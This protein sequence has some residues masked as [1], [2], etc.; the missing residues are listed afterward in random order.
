MIF[1][2]YNNW[3]NLNRIILNFVKSSF[4]S[5]YANDVIVSIHGQMIFNNNVAKYL[6]LLIDNK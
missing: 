5:F 6:G 4:L 3:C 2:K 1:A